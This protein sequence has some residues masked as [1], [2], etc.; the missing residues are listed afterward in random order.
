[1]VYWGALRGFSGYPAHF[2]FPISFENGRITIK[3]RLM[4]DVKETNLFDIEDE[5]FDKV[6]EP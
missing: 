5:S 1:M 3:L 2:T 4:V 6:I